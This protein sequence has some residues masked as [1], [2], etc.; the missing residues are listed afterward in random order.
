MGLH[1][2]VLLRMNE[3]MYV[4]TYIAWSI[5]DVAFDSE[6]TPIRPKTPVCKPERVLWYRLH[7]ISCQIA[8]S[9]RYKDILADQYF[10]TV[11][12]NA[13]W[14]SGRT[15]VQ[16]RFIEDCFHHT[17]RWFFSHLLDCFMI[18]LLGKLEAENQ[19]HSLVDELGVIDWRNTYNVSARLCIDIEPGLS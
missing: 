3:R 1:K 2:S 8:L 12:E 15:K 14:P 11:L 10:T 16:R 9:H 4:A 7:R 17:A 13:S 18:L 5:Y 6:I 19:D